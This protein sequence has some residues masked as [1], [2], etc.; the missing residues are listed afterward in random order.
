MTPHEALRLQLAAT[1]EQ[2]LKSTAALA[3]LRQRLHLAHPTAGDDVA[4][5]ADVA[6]YAGYLTR[7]LA[8]LQGRGHG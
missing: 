8:E 2:L 1:H 6:Y 5:L 4:Q 3:A 7:R